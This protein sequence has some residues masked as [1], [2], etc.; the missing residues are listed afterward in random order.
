M[1][2]LDVHT[3]EKCV[4]SLKQGREYIPY[5][6]SV[7]TRYTI[8]NQ[9]IQKQNNTQHKINTKS[10]QNQHKINTKSTQNAPFHKMREKQICWQ[11]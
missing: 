3:L 8:Q 6:M 4:R 5:G 2:N 11:I 10:I 7:T 9:N 1:L